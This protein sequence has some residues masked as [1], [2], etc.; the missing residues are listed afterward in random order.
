VHTSVKTE[1]LNTL[2]QPE[3]SENTGRIPKLVGIL[4]TDKEDAASYAEVS[5]GFGVVGLGY[6][7]G[8]GEVARCP[9]L[10]EGRREGYVG[11]GRI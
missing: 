4:A 8:F 10:D 11:G 5:F 7:L 2:S 1:L 9:R 6:G 3:F